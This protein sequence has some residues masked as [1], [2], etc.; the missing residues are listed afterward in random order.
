MTGEHVIWHDLDCGG[1]EADLDLWRELAAQAHGPVLDLGAGT[2]R[3]TV[4]LARR[5]HEVVAVD[6]DAELLAALRG[7]V[8]G[9]TVDV[10][11]ADL[12]EL[13]L[14]RRFSLV[15]VPMQTVQLL[16]GAQGR[17]PFLEGAR[18]HVAE[19]GLLAMAI[20][21]EL[22]EY[23]GPVEEAPLPDIRELEGVV[24]SVRPV[25]VVDEGAQFAIDRVRE[26]IDPGGGRRVTND[27]VRLDALEPGVLEAEGRQAG[28]T[29]LPRRTIDETYEYVGSTVVMLGG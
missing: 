7:R 15:L 16:G 9:L 20:A 19:G 12:R 5:G 25:S 2:G 28:F 26:V 21:D 1:Y 24:Y 23:L 27:V 18:A 10:V 14:G 6:S 3:V 11:C 13:D 4:D 17:A 22:Q 29:V 8:G